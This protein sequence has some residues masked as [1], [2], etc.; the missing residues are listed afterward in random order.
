MTQG[1]NLIVYTFN[2]MLYTIEKETCAKIPGLEKL[3][4]L[5]SI[6][7]REHFEKKVKDFFD[8]NNHNSVLLIFADMQT[9]SKNR[10]NMCRSII[11]NQRLKRSLS[12][13]EH[14]VLPVKHVCFL[15]RIDQNKDD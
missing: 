11:N 6:F 7:K 10:I 2:A 12:K 13:E 14:E 8:P 15:V 5:N 4:N 3:I 9:D 1:F